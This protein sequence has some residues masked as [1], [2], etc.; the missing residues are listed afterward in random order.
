MNDEA[1]SENKSKPKR[2]VG[3]PPKL[4]PSERISDTPENI[5]KALLQT[6]PEKVK[7]WRDS[8]VDC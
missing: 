1:G 6:P 5:A 8:Q 3:R 7:A 2:S 4:V